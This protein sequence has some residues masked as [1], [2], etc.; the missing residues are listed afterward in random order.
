MENKFSK[1]LNSLPTDFNDYKFVYR[2]FVSENENGEY[3]VKDEIIEGIIV[4]EETKEICFV[5]NETWNK[6][7]N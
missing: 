7:R 5:D 6:L 1:F 3:L 2:K 4:D